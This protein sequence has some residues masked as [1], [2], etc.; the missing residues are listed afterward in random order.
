MMSRRTDIIFCILWLPIFYSAYCMQTILLVHG[1][2]SYLLTVSQQMLDGGKYGFDFFETNP[3][4]ILYLYSIPLTISKYVSVDLIFTFRL[5]VLTL[6]LI[7]SGLSFCLLRKLIHQKRVLYPVVV[8]LLFGFLFLPADEFGQREHLFYV[9]VMPYVFLKAQRLEA[10]RI[11]P[12]LSLIVGVMAGIGFAIKPFFLIPLAFI[13]LYSVLQKRTLN[14]L[15]QAE[16][17]CVL[18]ICV[19]YLVSTYYFQPGY[20]KIIMPLV[21]QLYFPGIRE[22]W[23]SV[24]SDLVV[25][26]SVA[27]LLGFYVYK[28]HSL[29]A[30]LSNVLFYATLGVLL[31]WLI[32]LTTWHSHNIPTLAFSCVLMTLLLSETISVLS[33]RYVALFLYVA[34]LYFFVP[35]YTI[36]FATYESYQKAYY[37]AY[38][39]L[40][41]YFSKAPGDHSMLC[42]SPTTTQDCFPLVNETHSRYASRFPFQWWMRG[43][44]RLSQSPTAV[45]YK[46]DL[47]DLLSEDLNHLKPRWI[48]I[49]TESARYV[50]GDD[51]DYI[52]FF[53]ENPTFKNAW[54]SY[55]YLMSAQPYQIYERNA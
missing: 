48:L 44:Y 35:V 12:V 49:N 42:F 8:A 13:E 50:F 52:T 9:L 39:I 22:P 19:S 2:V 34:V 21:N 31:S 36:V 43:V 55:H 7:S 3:P 46:K 11:S 6:I 17:I 10:L 51:F 47:V 28:K 25:I 37:S 53:S 16:T 23:W 41:D 38:P 32:T 18:L 4:L 40:V 29:Y 33:M 1:D 20:F 26:F 45:R 15:F 5:W 14:T 27:S 30:H 54:K 24:L